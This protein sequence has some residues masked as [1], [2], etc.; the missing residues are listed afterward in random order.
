M[1]INK[2]DNSK[3]VGIKSGFTLIEIVV[4]VGSLGIIITAMVGVILGTFRAQ[5]R[6][7]STNKVMEN[8]VW[9]AD[10]LRKNVFNSKGD[11][12]VCNLNGLSVQLRD[13][14]DDSLTTISCNKTANK[15][16]STSA[17]KEYILNNSE[18]KINNCS[19]FVTCEKD[20]SRLVVTKVIFNFD[21]GATTV[22]VSYSQNFKTEV[23]VRN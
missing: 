5:N 6:V 16:A 9:I 23:T 11:K 18:V 19:G 7:K 10:Q 3:T 17:T 1:M 13:S 20:S 22:G 4:V 12:I 8:G 2:E 14:I 15:I 21:I